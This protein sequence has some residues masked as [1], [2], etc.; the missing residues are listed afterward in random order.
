VAK[1]VVPTAAHCAEGEDPKGL[2]VMLGTHKLS[3]PG[4]IIPVKAIEVHESYAKDNTHDVAL[5][6]LAK[7]SNAKPIRLSGANEKELWSP[8][9]PARVIGW[10][11]E[12]FLVGPGS[13]DLKEVDVPMVDDADCDRV[14]GP[15]TGFDPTSMVCAGETTGGKDSCQGDSGGP[16][17]V[18]DVNENWIQV[19]V[20]SFGL[21]CGFP[22]FYGVY[23]RVGDDD[24]RSWVQSRL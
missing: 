18:K 24:L 19:G 7:K 8:G 14:Y 20:V 15:T 4:T 11:A 17:M 1:K 3:K 5:L 22:G 16:L 10:G 12:I 2:Q 23:S 9:S 21:G 13:D 6:Y